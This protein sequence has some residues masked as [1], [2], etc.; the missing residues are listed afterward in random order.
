MAEGKQA[1]SP[2]APPA[3]G[4]QARSPGAPPPEGKQYGSPQRDS[5]LAPHRL[6]EQPRED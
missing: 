4:K 2:G 3:E 6:D 5:S 1:R